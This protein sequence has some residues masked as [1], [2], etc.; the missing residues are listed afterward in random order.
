VL[1]EFAKRQNERRRGL[2]CAAIPRIRLRKGA[3]IADLIHDRRGQFPVCHCI[4]QKRGSPAILYLAQFF[5]VDE[6]KHAAEEILSDLLSRRQR[7]RVVRSRE[8]RASDVRSRELA[9]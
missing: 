6:A 9:A 5:T 8:T 3:L 7:R 1:I 4:I 2:N